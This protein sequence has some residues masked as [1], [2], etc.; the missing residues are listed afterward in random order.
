MNENK[1]KLLGLNVVNVTTRNT[2]MAQIGF[3]LEIIVIL[4]IP[5]NM[6]KCMCS[7]LCSSC[8]GYILTLWFV[9][10]MFF[11]FD[12]YGKVCSGDYI[13]D[14]KKEA[15]PFPNMM[16]AGT[17][18]KFYIIAIWACVLAMFI[19]VLL[20]SCCTDRTLKGVS[21]KEQGKK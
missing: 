12:H 8:C 1:D 15:S 19:S 6:I 5:L 10:L 17:Y 9:L 13:E 7:D 2:W 18:S 20:Y 21:E 11:R 3:Y 16:K 14:L 4:L